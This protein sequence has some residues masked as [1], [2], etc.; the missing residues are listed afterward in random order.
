MATLIGLTFLA[1]LCVGKAADA[2]YGPT[3]ME[4]RSWPPWPD[5]S[6]TQ[7]IDSSEQSSEH[8]HLF[9]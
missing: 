3:D 5:S 9:I 7:A 4:P 1:L 8:T 6:T 2:L